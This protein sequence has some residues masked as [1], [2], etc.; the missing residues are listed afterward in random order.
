MTSFASRL[1]AG[2]RQLGPL[3]VGI[4]PHPGRIPDLFGGDTPEGVAAW[5]EAVVAAAAGRARVV[6]PQV[7]LF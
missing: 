6:K 1:I 2:A 3:C 7:G 4:D 5:G